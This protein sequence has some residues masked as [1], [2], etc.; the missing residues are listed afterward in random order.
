MTKTNDVELLFNNF[1]TKLYKAHGDKYSVVSDVSDYKTGAS[2]LKFK[3]NVHGNEYEAQPRYVVKS[4]TGRCPLCE[5]EIN[6][7]SFVERAIKI[8]GDKYT[9]EFEKY[10]GMA[11]PMQIGCKLHG[12]F[13]KAPS[14]HLEGQGCTFCSKENENKQNLSNIKNKIEEKHGNKYI[15]LSSPEDYRTI[16]SKLLIRCYKHGEYKASASGV[17]NSKTGTCTQCALEEEANNFISKAVELHGEKY[18]YRPEDYISSRDYMSIKCN[19]H[20]TIFKQRPSAHLQGQN[21]PECGRGASASKIMMPEETVI[22]KLRDIFGDTYDYSKIVYAGVFDKVEIVCRKHGPFWIVPNNA[23]NCKRGG[24]CIKCNAELKA[25]EAAKSFVTNATKLFGDIYD[26]SDVVYKNNRV[27]VNIRC[28]VHDEWFSV[29]P[30]SLLSKGTG[31][32][33]CGK[34]RM[35]RWDISTVLRNKRVFCGKDGSCYLFRIQTSDTVYHKIGFTS[36]KTKKRLNMIVK[37]LPDCDCS[38]VGEYKGTLINSIKLEKVLHQMFYNN[39]CDNHSLVFGG[40][41][42]IFNLNEADIVKVLSIFR[43]IDTSI[44]D[45]ITT[46]RIPKMLLENI[47]IKAET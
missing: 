44:L 46:N 6:F 4:L 31:C 8:H 16:N 14:A 24:I 23:L 26:F 29:K 11:K 47:K 42:E 20:G 36:L 32:S 39:W 41:T 15:I 1:K 21:C 30:N 13:P 22:S 12:Y 28:K 18:S 43:N 45:Q 33:I 5:K 40:K 25:E 17:L 2:I 19:K 9:Y 10:L 3:C 35:S 34:S 7:N 38:I 27:P 37:E